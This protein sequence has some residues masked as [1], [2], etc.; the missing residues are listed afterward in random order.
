M[1]IITKNDVIW[2]KSSF[3]LTRV[4]P[5]GPWLHAGYFVFG[6]W[7]GNKYVAIER[8]MVVDINQIRADKGMPPMVGTH[9]WIRY[10]T[11]DE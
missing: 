1:F 5:I 4:T 10:S 2:S 9:A 11:E 7:A 8:R 6:A 3:Q